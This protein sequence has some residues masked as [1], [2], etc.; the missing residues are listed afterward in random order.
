MS[1]TG[2]STIAGRSVRGNGGTSHS[3]D[4]SNGAVLEPTYF[5]IGESEIEDAAI[6]AEKAFDFYRNTSP[7]DRAVFLESI[8]E[9]L[10]SIKKEIVERAH[11]E[12]GLT[13]A[14]LQGEHARTVN[15]LRLFAKELRLGAHQEVRI[16]SALPDRQPTPGPELRQRQVPLGPV[17]V[18]GASNFPL[19]FSVAGGDTASALAAGCPVIVKAHN[20][21][22]GTSE[23]AGQ[24]I[25]K[26]VTKCKLPA[27]VF[28]IIFGP[29]ASVGKSL[30]AHRAI[31]AIAFTGSQGAGTDLM[32]TAAGRPEPIPV[33]AEMSSINPVVLLPGA[34]AKDPDVIATGFVSSLT[35]GAGQF[36]TNPG[37]VLIPDDSSN[38]V[39]AIVSLVTKSTGQTML[40]SGISRAYEEGNKRLED[41][42][43]ELI[44]IGSVGASL[45][46][47]APTIFRCS[48]ELLRSQPAL[49]EEVFGYSALLVTYTGFEDLKTTL[50]LM[51]GQLTATIHAADVDYPQVAEIMPI[52]ER[53]VGRI[54]FNGWPTGVEVNHAMVHGGAFPATSD[55]RTTSVGTLAI[56]RFQ[57]PVSYQ[58]FP[59]RLLPVSI[60]DGNPWGLP[61]RV[62]GQLG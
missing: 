40:S 21:H 29:G 44:A 28:S 17:A 9:N 61:R 47:P 38:I 31:K 42:G 45:N 15:Q 7:T 14:R 58:N 50:E 11:K 12:T 30:A 43:A 57:R 16:D 27:G 2:Q 51:Q 60:S 62:N 18:F 8:A 55:S 10:E 4:P 54:V 24:A 19:A 53:K 25:T 34:I 32:R 59:N 49:Q 23:L 5:F 13:V 26:A 20:S 1:L 36:C 6:S 3:I 33:Y 22:A 52:L 46:A 35:L 48:A 39:E 56:Y 41:C 37:L